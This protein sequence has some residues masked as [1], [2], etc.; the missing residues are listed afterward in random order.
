L[1]LFSF[2]N[3]HGFQMWSFN[4]VREFLSILF[5]CLKLFD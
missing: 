1:H 2:F 4:G 5:T 3:A